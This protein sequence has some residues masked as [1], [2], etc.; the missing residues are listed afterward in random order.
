MRPINNLY[1]YDSETDMPYHTQITHHIA[2]RNGS[3]C[4]KMNLHLLI[5]L[6]FMQIERYKF[7]YNVHT[8]SRLFVV[9]VMEA[10]CW[11]CA[12]DYKCS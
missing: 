10:V 9:I 3:L 7:E 12:N 8:K 11:I 2:I 1:N 4:H 5:K 6:Q